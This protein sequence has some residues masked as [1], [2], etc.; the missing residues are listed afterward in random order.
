M[1]EELKYDELNR[2]IDSIIAGGEFASTGDEDVDALTRL[3]TGLR[4]LANPDFKARLRA[5]LVPGSSRP[6]WWPFR[7][8]TSGEDVGSRPEDQR[9]GGPIAPT[10]T[11]LPVLSWLKGQ[12]AFV[13]AGGSWGVVAGACCISGATANVLGIASAAAVSE[14][15]QS[16]LPYF[17]ALS[18]AGLVGWLIWF[19]RE[20]GLTPTTVALTIRRHGVAMAGSYGL[21]FG[22]SMGLTMAMGLY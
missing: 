5:E 11:G 9:S 10:I 8:T 6:A 14:F 2:S 7:R 19:L 1:T 13:A 18:I 3:A 21:V 15:I 12:R 16:T 20:Q 4:G 22:A 17:V